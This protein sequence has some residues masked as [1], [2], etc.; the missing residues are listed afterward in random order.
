MN[1]LFYLRMIINL[2]DNMIPSSIRN[3]GEFIKL[4]RLVKKG[5]T[6]LYKAGKGTA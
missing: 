6:C 4:I 3:A 1:V 5:V 2:K